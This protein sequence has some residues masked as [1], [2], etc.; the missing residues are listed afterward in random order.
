MNNK[1]IGIAL[2][3]GPFIGLILVLTAWAIVSFVVSNL[4]SASPASAAS[5]AQADSV[6]RNGNRI[7]NAN[8]PTDLGTSE[9]R[10]GAGDT[11]QTVARIINVALGFLGILCVLAIFICVPLGI[12]FLVKKDYDP[13]VK[14][15][16]R[17]GKGKGSVV[18][19]EIKGWNWGA[20]GL[21][22]IWGLY[23]N[24][25]ISLLNFIPVVNWFWWIFLGVYGN[26]WAWKKQRWTSVAEFK[27]TQRKW[28]PWG[29]V[30]FILWSLS[31]ALYFFSAVANQ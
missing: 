21:G 10:L 3:L 19:D 6:Y 18:P 27:D 31:W 9:V 5:I 1:K 13:K 26:E 24:V 16:E 30:F 7:Y 29:I 22:I 8:V 20:A 17:S 14:Y 2:I 11:R 12:I 15:D 25:W 4:V 28:M 23:H